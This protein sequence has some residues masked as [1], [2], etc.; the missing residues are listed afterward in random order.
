MSFRARKTWAQI[1]VFGDSRKREIHTFDG[2]G[3]HF[4]LKMTF[5]MSLE[6]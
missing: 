2:F 6:G 5:N 4:L 1:K 3:A